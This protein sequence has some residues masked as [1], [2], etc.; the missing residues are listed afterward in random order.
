MSVHTFVVWKVDIAN[1][2]RAMMWRPQ[3]FV[4]KKTDSTKADPTK[5][6]N[7]KADIKD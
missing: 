1:F 2:F 4:I 7:E 5:F 3:T 6:C